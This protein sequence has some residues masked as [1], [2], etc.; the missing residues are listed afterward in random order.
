M[1]P[2]LLMPAGNIEKLKY[3]IN[4]GADAVYLGVVD[5]SLRSMRKGSIIT[6]EN[7]KEAID[8][9][10]AFGAK[11]YMTLNIFPFNEDIKHLEQTIDIVK[12]ANP[13]AIILSD[14]GVFRIIKKYM[15]N[16]PIHISTQANI[17]N[18]EAVKFYRDEGAQ[19]VIL[20]RELPIKDVKEIKEAV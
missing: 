11:A 7:L 4:Y 12:A 18:Y 15:P 10:H 2:E 1:K 20:A 5:F 8:T 19:R 14:L 13:D 17:L 3:A 9:A 6:F 16:T